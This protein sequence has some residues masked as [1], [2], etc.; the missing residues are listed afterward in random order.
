MVVYNPAAGRNGELEQVREALTDRGADL[1]WISTTTRD[2]GVGVARDAAEEGASAVI[3]VGGDGTA[4]SCAEGLLGSGVPLGLIPIG[5]GNL[6]ARGLGIPIA[7]AESVAV[8]LLGSTRMIDVGLANGE[9]FVVMAGMGLDARMIK[10]ADPGLK[11]R[12]GPIAYLASAARHLRRPPFAVSLVLDGDRER[13]YRATMVLVANLGELPGGVSLFPDA[14]P[15]DGLL[16]VLIVEATGVL[17]WLGVVAATLMR[18]RR[19]GIHRHSARR[20][21]IRTT[22]PQPY[23][24]DGEERPRTRR[25]E[26]SVRPAALSCVV[27]GDRS[28]NAAPDTPTERLP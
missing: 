15:A 6:L 18:R 7:V 27:P 3:A 12:L 22:S 21:E 16:D 24:V 19:A 26:L 25:V 13:S 10:D 9:P 20:A 11:S 23:E 4:R 1:P 2:P 28:G 5:T 8:A 14:D 17:G